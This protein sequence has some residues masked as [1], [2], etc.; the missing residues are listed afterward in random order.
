MGCSLIVSSLVSPPGSDVGVTSVVDGAGSVGVGVVAGGVTGNVPTGGG[1]VGVCP[2][3]SGV[4]GGG[5]TGVGAVGGG[6]WGKSPMAGGT[7]E[8]VVVPPGG[9]TGVV[10]LVDQV[11]AG[12]FGVPVSLSPPHAASTSTPS[13][14][15]LTS[16]VDDNA[17]RFE[18]RAVTDKE[19]EEGRWVMLRWSEEFDK[20]ETSRSHARALRK[21]RYV[22]PV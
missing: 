17:A 2:V 20:S 5:V 3:G 18:W 22:P 4:V 16:A 13:R 9:A 19:E 15:V 6:F 10:V 12:L 7:T 11:T 1:S 8:V 14:L 21:R